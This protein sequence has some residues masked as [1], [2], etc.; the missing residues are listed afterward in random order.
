CPYSREANACLRLEHVQGIS[1]VQH[2]FSEAISLPSDGVPLPFNPGW[3]LCK[4]SATAL[5]NAMAANMA[6]LR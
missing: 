3:G 4:S 1:W 6:Y 2:L 5:L